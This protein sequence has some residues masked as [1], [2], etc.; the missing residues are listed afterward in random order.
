MQ[1][2]LL[3]L[4]E[5]IDVSDRRLSDTI[6]VANLGKA[7]DFLNTIANDKQ[8]IRESDIRHLHELLVGD[9]SEVRPGAYRTTG[10]VISGA[11][12]AIDGG[13]SVWRRRLRSGSVLGGGVNGKMRMAVAVRRLVSTVSL[14]RTMW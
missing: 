9:R 2:T 6:E 14:M 7:F 13:R 1:E 5:G 10:V 8:T 4:K 12:H 11:E 3:V